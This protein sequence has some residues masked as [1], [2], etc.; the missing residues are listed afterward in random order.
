MNTQNELFQAQARDT[1]ELRA[2]GFNYTQSHLEMFKKQ[3]V[4]WRPN[5]DE[6]REPEYATVYIIP[7]EPPIHVFAQDGEADIGITINR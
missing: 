7:V 4:S 2:P 1:S 3:V 5:C 6:H